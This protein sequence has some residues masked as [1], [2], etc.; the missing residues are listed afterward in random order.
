MVFESCSEDSRTGNLLTSPEFTLLS[1]QVLTFTTASVKSSKYSTINVYQTSTLGRIG[2]LLG[3]YS[4]V[5]DNP[6]VM[7]VTHSVCLPAGTYQLVFIASDDENDPKSTAAITE[8][9]LS[10]S[11]CT[12]TSLA[13]NQ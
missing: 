13:G 7:N 4:I 2:T 5:W 1:D 10:N 3:S 6:G 9:L 11:S 12:Y 8:V